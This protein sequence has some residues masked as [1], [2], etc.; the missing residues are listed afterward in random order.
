MGNSMVCKRSTDHILIF[1]NNQ[2]DWI[3]LIRW[4]VGKIYGKVHWVILHPS[5]TLQESPVHLAWTSLANFC[6]SSDGNRIENGVKAGDFFPSKTGDSTWHFG[7]FETETMGIYPLE[8]VEMRIESLVFV[9]LCSGLISEFQS[10]VHLWECDQSFQS[11]GQN[12]FVDQ[13]NRIRSA[14]RVTRVAWGA[15]GLILLL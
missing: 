14:D 12:F 11:I 1:K 9:C 6:L 15:V 2:I 8:R 10:Q 4:I 13:Q 7:W 5:S 3:V